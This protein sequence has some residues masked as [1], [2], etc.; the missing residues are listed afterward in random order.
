MRLEDV[1]AQR[2]DTQECIAQCPQRGEIYGSK[3]MSQ[4]FPLYGRL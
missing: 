1:S 4:H 3:L 2:R